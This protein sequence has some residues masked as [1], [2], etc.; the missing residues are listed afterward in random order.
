MSCHASLIASGGY[1]QSMVLL[2]LWLHQPI[3]ASSCQ[4]ALLCISFFSFLSLVRDL[5][6]RFRIHLYS[7]WFSSERSLPSSHLQRSFQIRSHSEVEGEWLLGNT[8]NSI[9]WV[10]NPIQIYIFVQAKTCWD[11]QMLNRMECQSGVLAWSQW[12]GCRATF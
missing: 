10:D 3:I 5:L 9:H 1:W 2:G 6:I 12:A 7:K 8:V 11:W 4:M